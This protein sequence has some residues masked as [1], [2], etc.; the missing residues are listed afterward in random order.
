MIAAAAAGT[1][2]VERLRQAE[3]IKS[4]I[5]AGLEWFGELAMFCARVARAMVTPPFESEE[6]VRQCDEIGS[7]RFR[8]WHLQ[9]EQRELCCRCRR[10]IA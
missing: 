9:A 6:L 8:W 3:V 10:A 7:S 2:P 1:V 5:V 4:S